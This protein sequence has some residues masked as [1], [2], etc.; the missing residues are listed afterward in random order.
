MSYITLVS[1]WTLVYYRTANGRS[2][3]Q[4]Y[5]EQLDLEAAAR[6]RFDLDLLE[7]FGLSLGAPYVRSIRGK[8][9]ELRTTGHTQHRVLYFA[10]SGRRLVL[11]HAFSKKT[12]KTP[13]SDIEIALRRMVDYQER[14]EE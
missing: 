4:E 13:R 12:Q 6:V 8:L 14:M 1:E 2:P 5:L 3:V 9:W 7:S 10:A 11:L